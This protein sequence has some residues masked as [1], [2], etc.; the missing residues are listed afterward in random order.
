[1]KGEVE[2]INKIYD[3]GCASI[4]FFR[5][6]VTPP[7]MKVML[8]ITE[9][10]N[11]RCEHCFN[12]ANHSGMVMPLDTIRDVL[13]PEFMKSKVTKVTLTGGEPL[14]HPEIREIVDAL[15]ESGIRVGF[16]TN[17]TLLDREWARR[18]PRSGNVHFNVSLD[19]LY[20]HT[21]G[22]FRGGMP[23]SLFDQ[24][25]DNIKEL[26]RLGLLNGILTTPN[27][28]ATIDEYAD[29]CKFAKNTGAKYVLMNPLSP[30]G[31]GTETQPLAFGDEEMVILKQK[32]EA[33]ITDHFD[34]VF[35]RFPNADHKPLGKCSLGS[36]PYISV[37]GDIQ[38]CPFL[39]L[40]AGDSSHYKPSD[41]ICGNIVSG[42]SLKDAVDRYLTT[43]RFGPSKEENCGASG[44]ECFA[45]T[46]SKN[47]EIFM[48]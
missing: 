35:I 23:E 5:S 3:S 17:A 33:L 25:M 16:T 4:C 30:F 11:L 43:A 39:Y 44:R 18:L 2:M 19:G 9:R 13:I 46:V 20:V 38:I 28:Y 41:F 42:D 34:V 7:C 48:V 24:L 12:D 15:L 32:T 31:R 47:Q 45:I 21:H 29:L 37:N 14:L 6:T 27:K 26:G 1:M 36:I 40:A 8:Q 22:R 10:C